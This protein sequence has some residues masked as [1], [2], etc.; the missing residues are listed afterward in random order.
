MPS[1]RPIVNGVKGI[2]VDGDVARLGREADAG[3]E[4]YELPL[5]AVV[6]VKEGINL[7]R[8]PTMKG[9][10]RRRRSPWPTSMPTARPGGLQIVRLLSARPSRS[11]QRRGPRSRADAAPAVVDLL[12]ELGVLP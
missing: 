10:L 1:G 8:Y 6:G 7:P 12:D 5:P 4:L 11:P 3:L 9:R 2:E